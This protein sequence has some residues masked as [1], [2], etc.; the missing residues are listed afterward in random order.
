MAGDHCEAGLVHDEFEVHR[1]TLAEGEGERDLPRAGRGFDRAPARGILKSVCGSRG[2]ADR[3]VPR[4]VAAVVGRKGKGCARVDVEGCSIS[5][6]IRTA[7]QGAR[8][9]EVEGLNRQP[10]ELCVPTEGSQHSNRGILPAE[11]SELCDA[12]LCRWGGVKVCGLGHPEF[13][14]SSAALGRY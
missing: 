10:S 12:G 1:R 7:D 4:H 2:I 13:S 9:I 5:G 14:R 11:E 6:G 3:S 8:L